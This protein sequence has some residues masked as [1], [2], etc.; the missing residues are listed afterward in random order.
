MET[1]RTSKTWGKKK[2]RKEKRVSDLGIVQNKKQ[3]F[4]YPVLSLFFEDIYPCK[5]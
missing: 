1:L 5:T 2:E 4:A 3:A